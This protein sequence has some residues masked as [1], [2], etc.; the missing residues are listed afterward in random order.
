VLCRA[1]RAEDCVLLV[2]WR[3]HGGGLG[4]AAHIVRVRQPYIPVKASVERVVAVCGAQVPENAQPCMAA[5]SSA[6]LVNGMSQQ[7]AVPFPDHAR[8]VATIRSQELCDRSLV[9]W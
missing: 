5:F 2:H 4:P 1:G 7:R 3:H 8:A 6:R 9:E